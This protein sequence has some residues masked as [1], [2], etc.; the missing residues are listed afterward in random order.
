MARTPGQSST[1]WAIEISSIP[2][3][4]R[5]SRQIVSR[6]SG[7][8]DMTMS[9]DDHLA[10]IDAIEKPTNED[11]EPI[12]QH[13]LE[14][15]YSGLEGME[16]EEAKR[17][18]RAVLRLRLRYLRHGSGK[19]KEQMDDKSLNGWLDMQFSCCLNN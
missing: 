10:I 17:L 5:N 11:L 2:F 3:G 16:I 12:V 19:F 13:L 8:I 14:N 18:T 1:T 7:Q 6:G 9:T 15:E 4:T